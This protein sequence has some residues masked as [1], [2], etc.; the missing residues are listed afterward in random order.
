MRQMPKSA[1][2]ISL[3]MFFAETNGNQNVGNGA[4]EYLQGQLSDRPIRRSKRP[5]EMGG[6]QD[7]DRGASIRP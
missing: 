7:V 3:G 1:G 2:R 6:D 5:Q 4:F